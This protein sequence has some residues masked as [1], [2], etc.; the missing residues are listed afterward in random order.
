LS[1]TVLPSEELL[2]RINDLKTKIV[3]EDIQKIA[4]NSSEFED[5]LKNYEKG[6][7]VWS[8]ADVIITEQIN[9]THEAWLENQPIVLS[10]QQFDAM[11]RLVVTQHAFE[12]SWL[13]IQLRELYSGRIDHVSK[14]DFYGELAQKAI[15][16]INFTN[17]ENSYEELLL[18]VLRQSKVYI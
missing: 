5:T 8:G 1:K 9:D 10:F 15:D 11:K 12:L 3:N 13:F 2:L 14:Y 7:N 17:D 4:K 18:A 6:N 16:T